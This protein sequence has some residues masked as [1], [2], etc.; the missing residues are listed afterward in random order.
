MAIFVLLFVLLV[1]CCFD[2]LRQK[3]ILGGRA[4]KDNLNDSRQYG[5]S[6]S[7]IRSKSESTINGLSN[8]I[9]SKLALE[10]NEAAIIWLPGDTLLELQS[11]TSSETSPVT[12]SEAKP[13]Q[14]RDRRTATS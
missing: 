4:E 8:D 7:L 11:R 1:Y 13:E 6:T 2:I 5:Q 14:T 12:H 9:R 10:G 3:P